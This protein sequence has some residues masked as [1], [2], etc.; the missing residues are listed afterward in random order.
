M[1]DIEAVRRRIDQLNGKGNGGNVRLWRPTEGEHTI[2]VLPWPT[3]LTQ[4]G[5]PFIERNVYFGI[6]KGPLVSPRSF[7]KPDPIDDFIRKLYDEAREG[8]AESKALADKLRPK[9]CTCAAIIDRA[10]ESAGPQLWSMN[11]VIARDVLNLFLNKQVGN[12]MDAE[13]GRD[14]IVTL[15]PSSRKFNGKTM[16]DTKIMPSFE[17]SPVSE[18]KGVAKKWMES[19]PNVD[20]YYRLHTFD[21]MKQRFEEWLSTGGPDRIVKGGPAVPPPAENQIDAIVAS[22]K[23]RRDSLKKGPAKPIE[24]AED[25]IN[26]MI[27]DVN[28]QD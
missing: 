9:L 13:S 18:D 27:K 2:R 26:K 11:I 23:E 4:D 25:E 1:I 3:K 22:M 21:E 12:F 6:G 10:D 20:E 19:L 7:G 5:M 17:R 15:Q 28:D 8:K 24:D 16:F 14:L